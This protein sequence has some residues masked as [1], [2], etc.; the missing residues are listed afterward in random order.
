[1]YGKFQWDPGCAMH[2]VVSEKP[3]KFVPPG[4]GNFWPTVLQFYL[5]RNLR[6]Q[7]GIEQVE[8]HGAEKL[9]ASIDAGHGVLLA[10]NHSRHCDPLVLGTLGRKANTFFYVMASWHLF[11]DGGLR[12]WLIQR[13]GAFSIYREGM[14]KAAITT[15]IDVLASAERPLIIFPEGVVSRANDRLNVLLEGTTFIARSA[16]KKRSKQ[17]PASK[18]VIHPV[19][20]KYHFEGDVEAA[21]TPVLDEIEHRL[22]WQPREQTLVERI[23]QVGEAILT[24][25]ELEHLGRPQV[26]ELHERIENLTDHL[27]DPLEQEWL[28]GK[29]ESTTMLRVKRLRSAIL[30]DLVEGELVESEK[31]RRWRQLANCYLAQQLAWYPPDYVRSNPT[32]ER[33]LETVERMEDDL[34]DKIRIHRPLRAVIYVDDPIEVGPKRERGVADPLLEELETRLRTMIDKHS[35]M[36]P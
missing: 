10:P 15:A 11:M 19:V 8:C 6:K 31:N 26:G 34:T 21:V 36:D 35:Q 4:R 9:K 32:P 3:Y 20:I 24:L 28:D 27:L 25:K 1:M 17:T 23:I 7:W 30:P 33:I 22:T 2:R 18:V 16:A 14:D 13:G 29:R 12:A 5:P